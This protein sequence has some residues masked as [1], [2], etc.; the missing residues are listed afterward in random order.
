LE[1]RGQITGWLGDNK[2]LFGLCFNASVFG[3]REVCTQCAYRQTRSRI[4]S[5]RASQISHSSDF[6]GF[7][8][9]F[10]RKGTT[11]QEMTTIRRTLLYQKESRLLSSAFFR[12]VRNQLVGSH[13]KWEGSGG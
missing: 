8:F 12:W 13:V 7:P 4:P 5:R 11:R 2:F 9:P 10:L 6:K 1:K 3:K